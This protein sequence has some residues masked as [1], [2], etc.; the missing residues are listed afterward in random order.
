MTELLTHACIAPSGHG[1][2]EPMREALAAT[3]TACQRVP[4]DKFVRKCFSSSEEPL[5]VCNESV[6]SSRLYKR[7]VEVLNERTDSLGDQSTRRV[8]ERWYSL[9][10]DNLCLEYEK[11]AVEA[12]DGSADLRDTVRRCSDAQDQASW[13]QENSKNSISRGLRSEA[14]TCRL[15]IEW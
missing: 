5:L 2:T 6:D 14:H 13:L 15:P 9:A 3:K 8:E 7:P 11:C 12:L 4:G 1:C 10:A